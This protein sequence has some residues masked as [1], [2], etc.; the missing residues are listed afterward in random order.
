MDYFPVVDY[1]DDEQVYLFD[2]YINV[3]KVFE[4]NTR[5]MSA[6][7]E[8]SLDDFNSAIALALNSLPADDSNPYV[9]Q[10]F[11]TKQAID[12]IGD[13]LEQ[14]INPQWRD[15]PLTQSVVELIRKQSDMLTHDK[16]IFPDSRMQGDVGWRVGEQKVYLVVY[17]KRSK[18]EW[19]K[20]KKTPAQQIEHD[21]TSF[22]TAMQSAGL[23]LSPLLPHQLVNWLSPF[24]GNEKRWTPQSMQEARELAS[25]DIG[26]L[27][28]SE[29]PRYY[30]NHSEDNERGIWQ[31][32][33][34]WSRYITL[35]GIEKCP[36]SGAIT[37]GEQQV[38]GSSLSLTASF[39]EKLPVGSMMTYTLIPQT[40]AQMKFEMSLVANKAA[41]TVSREADY[42]NEQAHTAYE[43]MMRNNEKIFYTQLGI[44]LSADRLET[45]LDHTETAISEVRSLRMIQIVD[46][47]WDLFPQHSYIKALPCVYDFKNDRNATLR[48][49][50]TYTSHIASL[51]PFFGNK[52]GGVNPCYIMYSRTGEPFYLNPFHPND[53]D[54]VSHEVFF[55]PTGS[56]KSAT[57]NY[58]TMMSSAVNNPRTFLFDYGGSFKLLADYFESKGKRV[59]RINFTRNSKDVVAPF[60]ETEKALLE[61]EQAKT[62]NAGTFN[63]GSADENSDASD[64]EENEEEIRTYLGEMESILRVMLTGGNDTANKNLTQTELSQLSQALARGLE[65]SVEQGEPHARPVHMADAMKELADE[66]RDNGMMDIAKSLYEKE[67]ALRRWTQGLHGI[68]FNRTATGLDPSYDLT[69]IEI[70]NLAKTPDMMA[71]AGLSAIYNITAMA[72]ELQYDGRSIEVKIDEAHLWAKIPML[73]D[74]LIVGAKVFRKLKTWLCII[75]QDVSDFVGDTA[76]ILTNAEFWHLM[77]MSVKEIK[78]ATEIL[79]LDEEVQHLIKFP[80]KESG[81]FVEGVSISEKYPD[82]LVRYVL[83]PL[84]LALAQTEGVEKEARLQM[85]KEYKCSELEAV[86]HIAEQIEQKQKEYQQAA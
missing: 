10:I 51:L 63:D 82:T 4:V 79:S 14:S 78:Q 34:K 6:K 53:K 65:M 37:L 33:R 31:F 48:A 36:R 46:P 32:G 7:S 9:V 17:R 16:G 28:F 81:R 67:A 18:S 73:I 70:G 60:F 69:V 64:E 35:G 30:H 45:L 58:M 24:F 71:V 20:S 42:A 74:G 50:K 2:D 21:L 62:I 54:R 26:Q 38:D 72:E 12:N 1:L 59:K 8:K 61:V 55:G 68:L 39:F 66:Q 23:S 22:Y 11:A 80:K 3:A 13:T 76:K 41:D 19:H 85:M 57:V 49:R 43:E 86:Y 15:D 25:S 5:Y 84:M 47:Q 56:G 83:P 29:Q 52:S 75:T 44:Y 27:I 77:K 40:D